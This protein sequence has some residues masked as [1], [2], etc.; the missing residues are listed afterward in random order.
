MGE[1][2]WKISSEMLE[3]REELGGS[4]AFPSFDFD[5][6]LGRFTRQLTCNDNVNM[7]NL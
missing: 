3:S 6:K 4:A 1:G 5:I 2:F 7:I